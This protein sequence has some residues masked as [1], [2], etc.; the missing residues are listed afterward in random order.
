MTEGNSKF[1]I[2]VNTLIAASDSKEWDIAIREW[3]V[4]ERYSIDIDSISGESFYETC[5]CSH[6]PIKE[7]F[8][9]TNTLNQNQLH[10][11]NCCITKII[12][13]NEFKRHASIFK[14]LKAQKLNK[15]IIKEAYFTDSFISEWELNFML[16]V[17]RKKSLS[18][19]QSV[20]F[21]RIKDQIMTFY[22]RKYDAAGQRLGFRGRGE[23]E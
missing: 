19:K 4:T 7:V 21:T 15:V 18:E 22:R 23:G 20:F 8:T 9:I 11:G 10:V 5:S 1:K 6:Y 12:E 3:K 2:L 14:A 13:P 17:F 16:N